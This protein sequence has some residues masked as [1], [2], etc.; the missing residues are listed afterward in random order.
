VNEFESKVKRLLSQ[1][2][3]AELGPRRPA[4]QLNFA[5]PGRLRV[6]PWLVPLL[7]AAGVAAA[8]AAIAV[9][10]HLVADRPS[11]G[12][13]V[14]RPIAP[15]TSAAAP[16][17]TSDPNA[18]PTP[19]PKPG[20]PVV[21]LDGARLQLPIGWVAREVPDPNQYYG[22]NVFSREWCLAP[23]GS[24]DPP[25]SGCPLQFGSIAPLVNGK[26][27]LANLEARPCPY[28]PE[29][30][31][32]GGQGSVRFGQRDAFHREWGGGECSDGTTR[33]NPWWIREYLVDTAP[34]YVL[35][36][37]QMTPLLD[38]A[39][40]EI[41]D[42]AS[43]PAQTA[44]LLLYD[45]GVVRTVTHQSDGYLMT[46][47]SIFTEGGWPYPGATVNRSYLIR[48]ADLKYAAVGARVV[49]TT[50]GTKVISIGEPI[51]GD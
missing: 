4:P 13:D 33:I 16:W 24:A 11:G 48:G 29:L 5:T 14:G 21:D 38:A 39:W 49:V 8:I 26:V 25:R 44:P 7:A 36:S 35:I 41:N 3:D 17:E 47:A 34:G 18:P 28:K 10:A 42:H 20:G 46:I 12:L 15:T 43:L 22:G 19:W 40:N 31:T 1:N 51:S 32:G 23:A 30:A 6:R 2:V 27:P 45:T 50:D 9:P 37:N